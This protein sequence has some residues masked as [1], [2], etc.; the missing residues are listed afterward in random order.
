MK[1]LIIVAIIFLFGCHLSKK[2]VDT[3][4]PVISYS[5]YYDHNSNLLLKV[6]TLDESIIDVDIHN[7]SFYLYSF[8]NKMEFETYVGGDEFNYYC[9][10]CH[11]QPDAKKLLVTKYEDTSLYIFLNKHVPNVYFTKYNLS[12]LDSYEVKAIMKYLRPNPSDT[13]KEWRY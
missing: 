5:K 2:V 7:D 11:S 12:Y 4:K 3:Y 13:I 6:T 1:Y 10:K 8:L 9:T